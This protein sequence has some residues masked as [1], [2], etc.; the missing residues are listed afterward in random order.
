MTLVPPPSTT[1]S[2]P[3]RTAGRLTARTPS[4]PRSS[5]GKPSATVPASALFN[6]SLRAKL[7]SY[8]LQL[9]KHAGAVSKLLLFDAEFVQ[10]R[11][12]HVRERDPLRGSNVLPAE[13]HLAVA[14]TDDDGRN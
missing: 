6:N 9:R 7:T 8:A 5:D 11:Q 1:A 2:L 4:C 14:S 13:F 10:Q 3:K 12:V